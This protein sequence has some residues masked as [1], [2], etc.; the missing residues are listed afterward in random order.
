[1][2]DRSDG[3]MMNNIYHKLFNMA[4]AV[5]NPVLATVIRAEG[6]TP[7][8]PGSSA[9]FAN[10]GLI[11]GTVE[12]GVVEGLLKEF[13]LACGKTRVSHFYDYSY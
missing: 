1:M 7:Q 11:T 4:P 10:R 9:I 12:G 8:K 2:I 6:S 5:K 13:A 3:T